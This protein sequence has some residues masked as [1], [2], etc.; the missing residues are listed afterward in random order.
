[1]S[2]HRKSPDE[3]RVSRKYKKIIQKKKVKHPTKPKKNDFPRPPKICDFLKDDPNEYHGW[4]CDCEFCSC[5]CDTGLNA[6]EEEWDLLLSD[7]NYMIDYRL[8]YMYKNLL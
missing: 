6:W 1:M 4:F 5:E 7:W 2:I 8:E 3:K